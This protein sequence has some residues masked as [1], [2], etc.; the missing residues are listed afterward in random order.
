MLNKSSPAIVIAFVVFLS[1]FLL[2]TAFL[3]ERLPR[4]S[5]DVRSLFPGSSANLDAF[6]RHSELFGDYLHD[7][8]VVDLSAVAKDRTEAILYELEERLLELEG[9]SEVISPSAS[10]SSR[11]RSP[12]PLKNSKFARFLVKIEG[13]LSDEQRVQLNTAINTQLKDFH[14]LHPARAGAFFVSESVAE[15]IGRETASRV[16]ITIAV[17]FVVAALMLRNLLH[18]LIVLLSP[19]VGVLWTVLIAAIADYRLGPIS[20]LMPPFVLA[21]GASYS[22]HVASRLIHS[23][24][25]QRA[26]TLAELR[27]AVSVAA[28]TTVVGLLSLRFMDIQAIDEFAL[29]S[30]I[31]IALSAWAALHLTPALLKYCIIPEAAVSTLGSH[32]IAKPRSVVL[33]L[34]IT[35]V[36]GLGITR[37]VVHTNPKMFLPRTSWERQQLEAAEAAFPGNRMLSLVFERSGMPLQERHF[38]LI[39]R[40]AERIQGYDTIF[41]TVCDRDFKPFRQLRQEFALTDSRG[42]GP[43]SITLPNGEASRI[44]FE[45][46]LE[47]APLLTLVESIERD[48]EQLL[49][50]E[51]DFSFSV[52][53]IELILA[54]QTSSIVRGILKSLLFTLGIVACMLFFFFRKLSIVAIGL[55][56]N[57]IPVLTVLGMI[58]LLY[59]HINLGAS[60]VGA[61]ALSIAVDNTFHFLLTWTETK[62]TEGQKG[63]ILRTQEHCFPS[64][65]TTTCIL[66]AGFLTMAFSEVL[67]VQQFGL[68]LSITLGI[69]LLADTLVLPYLVE[70]VEGKSV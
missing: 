42:D 50:Q 46:A 59:E 16:P 63:A 28:S 53:G 54:E 70:K 60:L 3:L 34:L 40:V 8:V 47:G 10:L 29:F 65:M 17:L 1:C 52:S 25:T 26:K 61:A 19:G 38:D 15:V 35:V 69:G 44:I 41:S 18:A 62:K 49:S 6:E 31:G 57:I 48:V 20:Q 22:V 7:V 23:D 32:G 36:S 37:I 51:G 11:F 56:P 12:L 9:V 55:V 33:V 43:A 39:A 30:S 2:A 5:S 68:L 67:P 21:V 13:E 45:T 24:A 58:G 4:V 64:F 14:V 27:R 66:T